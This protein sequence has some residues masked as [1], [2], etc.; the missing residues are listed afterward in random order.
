MYITQLDYQLTFEEIPI[1]EHDTPVLSPVSLR[2]NVLADVYADVAWFIQRQQ[3]QQVVLVYD[4]NN[5]DSV[6]ATKA[7][8]NNHIQVSLSLELSSLYQHS[9]VLR[10]CER[11]NNYHFLLLSFFLKSEHV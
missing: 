6:Q 3:W 2:V 4:E 9:N 1:H 10:V 8:H 5:E 7:L 11:H